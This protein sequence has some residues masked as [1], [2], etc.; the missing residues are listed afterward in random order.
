[1]FRF[2]KPTSIARSVT[3]SDLFAEFVAGS[4]AEGIWGMYDSPGS[5]MSHS[6]KTLKII[7]F[8]GWKHEQQFCTLIFVDILQLTHVHISLMQSERVV[9]NFIE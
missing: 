6:E 1:M 7:K 2:L 4:G 9:G 8:L 5:G 3:W